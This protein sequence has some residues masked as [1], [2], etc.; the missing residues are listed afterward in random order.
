MAIEAP[1]LKEV[2]LTALTLE[3]FEASCAP[4][5]II[6]GWLCAGQR[7]LRHGDVLTFDTDTLVLNGDASHGTRKCYQ[8]RLDMLEP[9]QQG[10]AR[11]GETR[12]IITLAD[13]DDTSEASLVDS[14][15]Y[16]NDGEGIEIDEAFLSN[17]VDGPEASTPDLYLEITPLL[18]PVSSSDDNHTIYVRTADLGRLGSLNGD[19]VR[20]LLEVRELLTDFS[21]LR[22]CFVRLPRQSIELFG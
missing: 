14:S 1:L 15:E 18:E 10:Y 4:G 12:F 11:K 22:P 5:S 8:Y 3:A 7:M 2:V 6:E 19:W 9:F 20:H 17:S 21:T 16:G 13:S